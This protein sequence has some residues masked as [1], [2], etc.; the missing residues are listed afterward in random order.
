[1]SYIEENDPFL[2]LSDTMGRLWMT[3]IWPWTFL[4][5]I[6][7]QQEEEEKKKNQKKKKKKTL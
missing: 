6:I 3:M 1:L 4:F 2:T 5:Y 7:P